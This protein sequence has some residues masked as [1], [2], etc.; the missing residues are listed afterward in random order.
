M[1]GNYQELAMTLFFSAS[2]VDAKKIDECLTEA[3]LEEKAIIDILSTRNKR[4][5]TKIKES[6]KKLYGKELQED[7][8]NELSGNYKKLALEILKCERSQEKNPDIKQCEE[9]AKNLKE[10]GAGNADLFIELFTKSSRTELKYIC[11]F[12]YKLEKKT[13]FQ[14]LDTEFSTSREENKLFKGILYGLLNPAEYFADKLKE[15]LKGIGTDDKTLI[16]TITSRKDKDMDKI[17][18]FFLKKYKNNLADEIDKNTVGEYK[19]LLLM[20][21][22]EGRKD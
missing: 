9:K 5:L 21:I 15:S 1:N 6:Y 20:L 17:K 2:D 12:Y 3:G 18:K 7:F 4:E 14:L 8:E 16:R 19:N 11:Q 13:I 10:K 22:G